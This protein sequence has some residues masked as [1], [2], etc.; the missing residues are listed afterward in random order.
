[1]RKDGTYLVPT[2]IAPVAIV[3]G[4]LGAGIPEFMVRKSEAVMSAHV[5]SFQR[6]LAAGVAIAAGSDAGTPFNEHGSLV[7]ELAL[8]V[9]YGMTPL[10]AMRSATSVAA[11]LLGLGAT[12]GRIAPGYVADLVAV[13]GDPAERVDALENVRTVFVSGRAIPKSA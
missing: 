11:E 9:K 12:L 5:Q 10:Q 2:L 13:A 1:M 3:S 4:G 8:M 6:A 7:P